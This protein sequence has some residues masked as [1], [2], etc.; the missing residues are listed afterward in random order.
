MRFSF[1]K[2][3]AMLLPLL[4]TVP[5]VPQSGPVTAMAQIIGGLQTGNMNW[6]RVY[7]NVRQVIAQQT[8]GT[9]RYLPLAQLGPVQNIVMVGGMQLLEAGSSTLDRSSLQ[10]LSIGR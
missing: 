6:G 8:G 2:R 3:A 1:A 4:L 7:P 9:G 5:A 10:E